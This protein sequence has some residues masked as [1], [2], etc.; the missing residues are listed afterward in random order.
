[1][2]HREE[3]EIA[4]VVTVTH[5][6]NEGASDKRGDS[7]EGTKREAVAGVEAWCPGSDGGPCR[8]GQGTSATQ[9][10]LSE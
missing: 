5:W 10:A 8:Q 7:E 9:G 4:E 1:M 6:E 2:G 3:S